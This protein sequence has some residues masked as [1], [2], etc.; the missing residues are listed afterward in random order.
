MTHTFPVTDFSSFLMINCWI[1]FLS[2]GGITVNLF[3]P[4]CLIGLIVGRNG[5]TVRK[6]QETT[7]TYIETPNTN[8][9]TSLAA[10][11]ISGQKGNVD[12]V[13]DQIVEHV[14][15]KNPDRRFRTD[16]LSG[17]D[18]QLVLVD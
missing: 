6:L 5:N 15:S 12:E 11:R 7:K 10:F 8:E 1:P 13:I 17:G 3:T 18:F 4:V 9:K 2:L 14:K 16:V